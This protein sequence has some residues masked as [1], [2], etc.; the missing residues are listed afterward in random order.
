MG[1]I[2][3]K[4]ALL[5]GGAVLLWALVSSV[6]AFTLDYQTEPIG[7]LNLGGQV[8]SATFSNLPAEAFNRVQLEINTEG[9]R[10]G[11]SITEYFFNY[12]VPIPAISLADPSVGTIE[13][14]NPDYLGFDRVINFNTGLVAGNVYT[15]ILLGLQIDA[16]SFVDANDGDFYASAKVFSGVEIG[17]LTDSISQGPT[18]AP[19]PSPVPEPATMLLL[20]FGLMGLA[21]IGRRL[22]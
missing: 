19:T 18:P 13:N 15:F 16:S 8:V 12:A 6:Q 1:G 2:M 3:K 22:H 4:R 21:L 7:S 5:F 17:Y 11:L 20:G 14:P 10:E 9:L